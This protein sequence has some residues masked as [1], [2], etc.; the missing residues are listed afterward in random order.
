MALLLTSFLHK[1]HSLELHRT[2]VIIV[3]WLFWDALYK[4]KSVSP[5]TSPTHPTI[6]NSDAILMFWKRAQI[7]MGIQAIT[8]PF[9]NGGCNFR[10]PLVSCVLPTRVSV[11]LMS[12]PCC[13]SLGISAEPTKYTTV[14]MN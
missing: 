8:I 13:R 3:I 2:T 7:C 10:M 6:H 14:F 9:I 11:L 4:M 12:P 5:Q 1:P